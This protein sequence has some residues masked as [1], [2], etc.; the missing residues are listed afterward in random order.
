MIP[1]KPKAP[2]ILLSALTLLGVSNAQED[3]GEKT[4]SARVEALRSRIH[5]MRMSLLLGGDK[6][7]S[8]EA[9]AIGFYGKKIETIDRGID[10]MEV[11]LSEKRASYKISLE[12]TLKANEA[13]ARQASMKRAQGLRHEIGSLE[14]DVGALQQKRG[15][16]SKLIGAVQARGREREVLAGR[17]EASGGFDD[18]FNLNLGVVGLVPDLPTTTSVTPLED[19]DFIRDLFQEDPRG[20]SRILFETDPVGYWQR[21]PLAPPQRALKNAMAFPLPDLPGQR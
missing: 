9:E 11:D 21:F 17:L 10:S 14:S 13:T 8:A 1:M 3:T 12:Q 20:A 7:K 16:L 5:D 6:V 2:L 18:D 19:D 15:N 4:S